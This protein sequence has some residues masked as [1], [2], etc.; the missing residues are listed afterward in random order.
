MSTRKP[1]R[2]ALWG[3]DRQRLA[4]RGD[5][6]GRSHASEKPL[7]DRGCGECRHLLFRYGGQR[8]GPQKRSRVGSSA[9]LCQADGSTAKQ[10]NLSACLEAADPILQNGSCRQRRHVAAWPARFAGPA[11]AVHGRR[12][13]ARSL[14]LNAESDSTLLASSVGVRRDN[15]CATCKAQLRIRYFPGGIAA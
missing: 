15:I 11:R 1:R 10:M 7:A 8:C 6:D 4:Y 12:G 3:L 9:A 2:R 5:S 13:E 14:A